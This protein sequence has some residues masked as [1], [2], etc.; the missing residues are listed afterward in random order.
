[1]AV[2]ELIFYLF[3]AVLIAAA[4]LV[5][6][7]RNPVHSVLFLV[8][9]FFNGAGLFLLA[10]AE[11]LAFTLI[12]VYVGAIMVLFLFVLMMLDI[13]LQRMREGFLNYLPLGVVI[14][15][16]LVVEMG[17]M[18]AGG[19]SGALLGEGGALGKPEVG[20]TTLLGRVLYDTY[21][22]PF[23]VAALVLL[24]A[25][26]AAIALTLRERPDAKKQE[27]AQQIRVRREDRVRLVDM[28]AEGVPEGTGEPPETKEDGV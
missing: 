1:M 18:L 3:A 19:A 27:P 20:N 10:G 25:L 5:I 26:V 6:T 22:L 7:A 2:A 23:E 12:L 16:I 4:F 13:N 21:L 15:F 24:V 11:F 17:A 14:A 28:P 8:L 9:A